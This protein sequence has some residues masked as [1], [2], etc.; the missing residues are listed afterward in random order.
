MF[1]G[2]GL[3]VLQNK[4]FLLRPS[5][6]SYDTGVNCTNMSFKLQPLNYELKRGSASLLVVSWRAPVIITLV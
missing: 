6:D 5:I 1:R 2:Y 4:Q 3:F